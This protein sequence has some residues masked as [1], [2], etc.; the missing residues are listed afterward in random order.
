VWEVPFIRDTWSEDNNSFNSSDSSD[1]EV[2]TAQ[3]Q[4][5]S[6]LSKRR[7]EYGLEE[8]IDNGILDFINKEKKILKK[9]DE[10]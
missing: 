5:K 3:T 2:E 9:G 7:E 6:L 4:I 1:D 10:A 8:D